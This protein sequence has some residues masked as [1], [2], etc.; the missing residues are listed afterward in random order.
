[1][2]SSQN[3]RT[4]FQLS[5]GDLTENEIN[6][7]VNDLSSKLSKTGDTLQG[8]LNC[9]STYRLTNVPNPSSNGDVANKIYVDN[10][11]K[12]STLSLTF[13]DNGLE[14]DI[15]GSILL[16]LN[17]IA[18]PTEYYNGRIAY[19]HVQHIDFTN[20]AVARSLKKFQISGSVWQFVSNLTSSI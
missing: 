17:D 19:V 16:L 5:S 1:M 2:S 11:I 20:R 13:V 9:D 7:L 8:N 18:N 12:L 10:N 14:A 15:N 3:Y 4:A 6:D